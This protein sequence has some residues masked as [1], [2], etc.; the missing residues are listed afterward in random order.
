MR[1]HVDGAARLTHSVF[2]DD[3]LS[4]ARRSER[5]AKMFCDLLK[6]CA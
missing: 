1:T 4:I 5:L 3:L 2:V 6:A